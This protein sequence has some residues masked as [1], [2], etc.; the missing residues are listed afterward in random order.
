LS[1]LFIGYYLVVISNYFLSTP[2]FNLQEVEQYTPFL[3][4]PLYIT[5][6]RSDRLLI[7]FCVSAMLVGLGFL[8]QGFVSFS[9]FRSLSVL[10]FD[11]F[12]GSVHPVYFSYLLVFAMLYIELETNFRYKYLF[13][14]A[15]LTFL[16]LSGSKLVLLGLVV[17][18]ALIG[19]KQYRL[20][21]LGLFA[22]SLI[23]FQPLRDRVGSVLGLKD[24]SVVSEVP[25][26]NPEDPRINGLTMRLMLWQESMS[27]EG[28]TQT[29]LGRGV[30]AAG[31]DAFKEQLK[32]RGLTSH[33][34]MNAHNQYLTSYY[35]MGLLG[36]TMLIAI[37]YEC[38]RVWSIY[39]TRTILLWFTILFAA[40]MMTESVLE[41][42]VGIVLFG[43]IGLLLSRR[44]K[45]ERGQEI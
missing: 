30:G 17:V 36:L 31:E 43:L 11:E 32:K 19:R 5:C 26:V 20:I 33:L 27:Y 22:L 1:L 40:A 38:F 41:R 8:I 6:V 12:T 28:L 37:L 16:V 25:V 44:V 45:S 34:S 2:S 18:A 15:C 7:F 35:L 14:A 29:L 3:F 21:A 24:L 39:R 4:L 9:I 10:S 23:A 13:H 42:L